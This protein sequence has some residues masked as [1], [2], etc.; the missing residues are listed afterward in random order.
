V[1][2][3]PVTMYRPNATIIPMTYTV[4]NGQYVIPGAERIVKPRRRSFRTD[5]DQLVIPGAERISTRKYLA[6][7]A[8]KPMLPR[9]GQIGLHGTSLFGTNTESW[10]Q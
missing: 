6:R 4:E 3:I 5:G 10:R 8:A 7:I 2:T 1:Q 9:R